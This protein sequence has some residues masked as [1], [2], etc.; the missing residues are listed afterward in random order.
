MFSFLTLD[1]RVGGG[2]IASTNIKREEELQS[3]IKGNFNSQNQLNGGGSKSFVNTTKN[4]SQYSKMGGARPLSLTSLY[5]INYTSS[6]VL[7]GGG[8]NPYKRGGMLF[9]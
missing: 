5:D 2:K 7:I 6:D 8:R 4:A 1:L 9:I 3:K